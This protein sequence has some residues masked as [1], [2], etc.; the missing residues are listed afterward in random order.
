MRSLARKDAQ[1]EQLPRPDS[2]HEG[3]QAEQAE[4]QEK[5]KL[6]LTLILPTFPFPTMPLTVTTAPALRTFVPLGPALPRSISNGSPSPFTASLWL[7][8]CAFF[9]AGAIYRR[10]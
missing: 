5:T 8:V 3:S 9:L 6:P 1:S 4:Y 10:W 2:S 7:I